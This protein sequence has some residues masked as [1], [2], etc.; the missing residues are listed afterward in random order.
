[1]GTA[2]N[3]GGIRVTPLNRSDALDAVASAIAAPKVDPLLITFLNPDYARRAFID[4]ALR[5]RIN[6]FDLVLTDGVGVQLIAPLFGFRIPERLTTDSLVP[7]LLAECSTADKSVF[8]F[9]SAPG[10]AEDAAASL[11]T[12]F[13]TL[14]VVGT[15]HGYDDVLAGH[16]GFIAESD[17]ARIVELV[18]RARPDLLLV[19]LPTPLQQRWLTDMRQRLNV[20]AALTVGSYFDHV[21]E[22]GASSLS[23]YPHWIDALR[24]N[25]A[26][27]LFRDPDRLWRR[28]T[29][30]GFDYARLLLA[31]RWAQR[32]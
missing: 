24:L 9:G 26:Y 7:Q 19:G 1:M 32:G 5:E 8:L 22:A 4:P 6:A 20:S 18:N 27:R 2:G 14:R 16:P 3:F 28:Y 17:S 21:A 13:P 30:E 15:H 29:L 31:A 23:W 11:M 12:H 10:V 25:W